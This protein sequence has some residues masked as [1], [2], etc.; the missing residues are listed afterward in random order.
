[1]EQ[2]QNDFS[3]EWLSRSTDFLHAILEGEAP[4]PDRACSNCTS[5]EGFWRCL[6]CIGSRLFCNDCIWSTHQQLPFHRVEQWTGNHF[7]PSWLSKAGVKIY[8]GHFGKPCPCSENGCDEPMDEDADWEDA[9]FVNPFKSSTAK[10]LV[11]VDSSGVHQLPVVW[12]QCPGEDHE[13]DRR[14]DLDLL[15][16]GLY[17]ASFRR[18][19]TVFTFAV[20]DEFLLQNLEC[21]TSAQNFYSKLRRTT[22]KAFLDI[23]PDRYRE[24]LRI[25]RQWRYL[26]YQKWHGLGHDFI[27]ETSDPSFSAAE[28]SMAI[29]CPACPQP[30]INLP[31]NWMSLKDK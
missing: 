3:R 17:P 19:Q 11:I 27:S 25:S 21:K 23:V 26:K 16:M 12:C 4:P 5:R 7:Q 8:T 6:G 30:G 9:E 20:L 10:D 2:S 28:G 24:L 29:F 1:M 18:I 14:R 13:P 15:K 31:D 22:S